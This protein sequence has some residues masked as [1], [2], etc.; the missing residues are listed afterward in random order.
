MIAVVSLMIAVLAAIGEII[1][2]LTV[3]VMVM[4]ITLVAVVVVV[5]VAVVVVVVTTTLLLVLIL[6]LLP[7]PLPPLPPP[8]PP[9]FHVKFT[10][11]QTSVHQL[12]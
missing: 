9:L 8:L 1:H 4:E 6:L 10:P 2:F 11:L 7:P 5:V 3:S 12:V